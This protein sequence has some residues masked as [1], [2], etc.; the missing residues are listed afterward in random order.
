MAPR[1]KKPTTP[2]AKRQAFIQWLATLQNPNRIL[3]KK[4][5]ASCRQVLP[6]LEQTAALYLAVY[7]GILPTND[8]IHLH[9]LL[10]DLPRNPRKGNTA[11]WTIPIS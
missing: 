10:Q 4:A 1:K 11:Q 8:C 6:L 2:E 7:D 9:I 3:V 5:D